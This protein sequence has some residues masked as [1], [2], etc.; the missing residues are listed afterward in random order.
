MR[1]GPR[2]LGLLRRVLPIDR[3]IKRKKKR[4]GRQKTAKKTPYKEESPG[5][6]PPASA[7]GSGR[8]G[9][10]CNPFCLGASFAVGNLYS[11]A[12]RFG[13]IQQGA[14]ARA[15]FSKGNSSMHRV[16]KLAGLQLATDTGDSVRLGDLWA[17]TAAVVVFI[18][19]FG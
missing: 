15:I 8:R 3:P 9:L 18:R 14:L 12:A 6:A 19:H 10:P 13:A 16:T 11:S 5:R 1:T 4:R 2:F 17:D 7:L